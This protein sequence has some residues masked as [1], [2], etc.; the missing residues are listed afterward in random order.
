LKLHTEFRVVVTPD[1]DSDHRDHLHLEVF[2]DAEV[3]TPA[4]PTAA[5]STSPPP[6]PPPARHGGERA[7]QAR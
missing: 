5:P 2:P 4:P 7:R 1:D 6:V 3:P